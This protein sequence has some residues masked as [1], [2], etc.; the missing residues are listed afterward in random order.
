MP[1]G[2][3]WTLRSDLICPRRYLGECGH[4]LDGKKIANLTGGLWFQ[5]LFGNF[6]YHSMAGIA[7]CERLNGRPDEN[8]QC[9]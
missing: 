7:P 5:E 9:R 2:C 1:R 6:G 4:I 3:F 8:K